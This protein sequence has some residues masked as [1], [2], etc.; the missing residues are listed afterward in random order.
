MSQLDTSK[1]SLSVNLTWELWGLYTFLV[2]GNV[3]LGTCGLRLIGRPKNILFTL[4]SIFLIL[5]SQSE[6]QL[7]A[8][9]SFG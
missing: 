2:D 1:I 3:F 5:E 9:A 8:M 4:Q 6:F 7:L